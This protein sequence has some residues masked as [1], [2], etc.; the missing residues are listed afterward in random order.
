MVITTYDLLNYLR[1]RRYAALDRM[2]QNRQQLD[3]SFT[4]QQALT[5]LSVEN[6]YHFIGF[7]QEESE[8]GNP[9]AL[10]KDQTNQALLSIKQLIQQTMKERYPSSTS[11]M[12]AT[13]Q[14]DFAKE[15]SLR[16]NIDL[17]ITQQEEDWNFTILPMTD[18]EFL[19]MTIQVNKQKWPLFYVDVEG[20]Y[21]M[22][23]ITKED[24]VVSNYKDRVSKLKDRHQDVGRHIYD[25]AFQATILSRNQQ[26]STQRYFLA[27]LHKDYVYDGKVL[28]GIPLYQQDLVRI[29]DFTSLVQ[30]M[31]PQ[32]E[33]DLYRM[34][35]LIELNDDSPCPLVKNECMR[36]QPFECEFVPYCFSHIP[37]KN[38]IYHYF[39]HHLGFR[40]G[41]Q[42]SDPLHDTYDLLNEGKVDMLDIPIQWLQRE[43]NLMQ[44]YCVENNVP[45]INKKKVKTILDELIYPLYYLDFEAY[46]AMLPRFI[47]E[48]PYSQSVFQF[49]LH[50]QN[51][52]FQDKFIPKL[53]HV[54]YLAPTLGDHRLDFVEALLQA[55]PQGD[56]SII[57]YNK[58]FE[59]NRLLELAQLFPQHQKRLLELES[60]LVDLL[61]V[62]KNDYAFYIEKGFSKNEAETYNFYHPELSGSYSLKKVI[63]IFS[64]TGYDHLKI[65]NGLCAYLNYASLPKYDAILQEETKT[66]LRAYCEKDTYAMVEIH[67]G[68][69]KLIS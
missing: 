69:R 36:S 24:H 3:S 2:N 13:Y 54:E 25:L 26:P 62:L 1:C 52:P 35:N 16:T 19:E 42:K 27:V 40:E 18:R 12:D 22:H 48:K 21:R 9:K 32:V 28:D 10:H 15:H 61:K 31:L 56:S 68:L 23:T 57:V 63:A 33:A 60:R 17:V 58:T 67:H 5:Y 65:N 29:F 45:T 6:N 46:P 37:T 7:E 44:R 59:K 34:L 41:Q 4:N 11:R 39:N 66:A 51:A 38:A 50:I 20:F 49:S 43:K 8:S 53:N 14:C 30:E 64:K 55:I 47:G